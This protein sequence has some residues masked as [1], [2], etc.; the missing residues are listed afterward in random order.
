MVFAWQVWSFG[1]EEAE[2]AW[3][4]A[5]QTAPA[6]PRS[7]LTCVPQYP[8]PCAAKQGITELL[9]DLERRQII[10]CNHFPYNSPVWPVLKP[11]GWWCSTIDYRKLNNNTLPLTA[12][13]PSITSVVTAIQA[14]A[15]S[16]VATLDVKD[17][18]FMVLLREEDNPQFAFTWE[19]TQYNFNA[20]LQGYKHSPIIAHNAVAKLLDTVK[21]PEAST[22]ITNRRHLNWIC[23]SHLVL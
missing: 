21:V 5:L 4:W 16:W 1:G 15:H 7:K 22:S 2:A 8:L 10:N 12:T 3:V 11:D 13:V 23:C 14:A 18:V 6:L 9:G 19:G 20:L 17:M